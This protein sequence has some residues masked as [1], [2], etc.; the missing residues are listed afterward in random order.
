MDYFFE[1]QDIVTQI[2]F[3]CVVKRGE[4]SSVHKN[5]PSHGLALHFGDDKTYTF[6]TGENFCLKKGE[7]IYFPKGSNYIVEINNNAYTETYCINYQIANEQKCAAPFCLRVKKVE[8]I[9]SAYQRAE[10]AWRRNK[11]G[12]QLLCKAELYKIIY[13]LT[14]EK[15]DPYLPESRQNL[16]KPAVEYIHKNYTEELVSMEFLSELCGISYDYFRR[17]FKKYHGTSPVKYINSLKLKRAKELL[18]SGFY[19]VSEV[20]FASGFS[21]L[22]HFSRFFKAHVGVL[23]SEY[24]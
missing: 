24:R 4:G 22:S 14:Q 21:D 11:E 12:V 8:E 16:L 6:D 5:R 23:P 3:A 2:V 9:L 1:E 19:S 17:L 10:K 18:A 20:A 7:M 13:E 15:N